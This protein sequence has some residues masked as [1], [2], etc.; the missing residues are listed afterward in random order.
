MV[1]PAMQEG[2]I[3]ATA[4]RAQIIQGRQTSRLWLL[5]L[6]PL[7]LSTLRQLQQNLRRNLHQEIPVLPLLLPL[8][9]HFVK[10]KHQHKHGPSSQCSSNLTTTQTPGKTKSQLTTATITLPLALTFTIEAPA[11]TTTTT[12]KTRRRR[13]NSSK[14]KINKMADRQEEIS[15]LPQAPEPKRVVF[16]PTSRTKPA[17]PGDEEATAILK[18]GEFQNVDTLTLSEASL[19]LNALTTKRRAERKNVND[20]EMLTKTLEYLDAF[21]RFKEKESV[22]AVER[23]LSSHKSL[24]KFERA[25]LGSLCCE[26]AEEA[27]TLIPSLAD[28]I[29]D[30]DLQELLDE[31]YKL[32]GR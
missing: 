16:P 22:E 26:T 31:M 23:L 14:I 4:G 2:T 7:H 28:K 25:Q 29:T 24:Q 10:V 18:L 13:I 15:N 20:T 21:A 6:R 30:D 17:P 3:G 12:A 9:T 8:R 19:V 1:P 11:A 32:M 5:H 27:K